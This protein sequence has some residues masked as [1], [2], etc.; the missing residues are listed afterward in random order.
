MYDQLNQIL[1]SDSALPESLI[2]VNGTDWQGQVRLC[3]CV[4]VCV[5]VCMLV[6]VCWCFS[7]NIYTLCV[8]AVRCRAAPGAEV[9]GG[10][11]VFGGRNPGGAVRRA[12]PHPEIVSIYST[13]NAHRDTHTHTHTREEFASLRLQEDSLSVFCLLFDPFL[14]FSSVSTSLVLSNQ[15]RKPRGDF[16]HC[17][18]LFNAVISDRK[19]IISLSQDI[20]IV[21]AR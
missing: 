20:T 3:V 9:S 10:L 4:C 1:L 8:F 5:C 6:C 15:V 18:R 16:A 2:L 19:L 21:K 14:F 11:H 13:A 17:H 7:L 12:H